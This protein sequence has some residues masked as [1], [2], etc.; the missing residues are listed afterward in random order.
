MKWIWKQLRYFLWLKWRRIYFSWRAKR[1]IRVLK[2]LDDVMRLA[3]WGR[4]RQR[5]FWRRFNK[6]FNGRA[7]LLDEMAKE[8]Y[9]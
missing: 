1:S 7:D 2:N 3:K 9:K 4:T 5:Q 8:L 6:D